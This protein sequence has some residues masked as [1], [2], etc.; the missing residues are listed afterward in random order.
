LL[1]AIVTKSGYKRITSKRASSTTTTTTTSIRGSTNNVPNGQGLDISNPFWFESEFP[2]ATVSLLPNNDAIIVPQYVTLG[3][4]TGVFVANILTGEPIWEFDI[5]NI[6]AFKGK[7]LVVKQVPFGRSR[8]SAAVD[9]EGNF[10]VGADVECKDP[11]FACTDD[12]GIPMLFAFKP[13]TPKGTDFGNAPAW[14]TTM[15]LKANVPI[16]A[17]SPVLRTGIFDDREVYFVAYDGTVGITI[18]E[19]CPTAN[20]ALECS[21]R[22]ICDCA[23]GI[24]ACEK[25]YGGKDC[26][27]YDSSQS[28]CDSANLNKKIEPGVIAA[29]VVVP[30]VALVFAASC[31]LT[32]QKNHPGRP[33]SELFSFGSGEASHTPLIGTGGGAS[34]SARY[35]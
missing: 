20:Q 2:Y 28:G 9:K 19:S 1:Q 13:L 15:G 17:S 26:N 18:G 12:E 31:I 10:F 3:N 32:W 29:A 30:I 35:T 11:P 21:D 5:I 27:T 4:T 6:T 8:S 33:L 7:E 22:G 25:C 24:C 34:A 16:G 14:L 23:T